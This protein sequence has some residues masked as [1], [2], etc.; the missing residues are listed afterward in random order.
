[1]IDFSFIHT[2]EGNSCVGY[3][4]DPEHS[5]SG[6]TIGSGFDLGARCEDE[7]SNSFSSDLAAKLKPY[8]TL[9]KHDAVKFLEQHPL[10]LSIEEVA[11]IN[12]FSKREAIKRLETMW[13]DDPNPSCLFDE[14]HDVQQTVIA[15]VAFQ[16]G[17]LKQ[18]T[19]AFWRQ[20]TSGDWIAAVNNLRDFKDR[21]P[22]RRNKE[23]DLLE[24]IPING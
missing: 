21:Y 1:M 14:L 20:V 7:L 16:Y 19:P 8:A 12:K 17:N 15:S 24:S 5:S 18:R 9:K 23:A 11:E 13:N 22:T 2:L 3:V 10:T 4:P 6:V